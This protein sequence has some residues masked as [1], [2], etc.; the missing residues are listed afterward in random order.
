MIPF[1]FLIIGLT[2]LG[3]LLLADHVKNRFRHTPSSRR[4]LAIEAVIAL[5]LSEAGALLI[6]HGNTVTTR[7]TLGLATAVPVYIV[8]AFFTV[9]VWR[10]RKQEGFDREIARL[11]RENSRWQA[12]VERLN[13]ELKDL[14]RQ[15]H[16]REEEGMRLGARLRA[17][18]DQLQAWISND[19]GYMRSHQVD[20]WTAELSVLDAGELQAQKERMIAQAAEATDEERAESIA[21][22]HLVDLV[23]LR[24]AYGSPNGPI[25]ELEQRLLQVKEARAR[26]DRRLAQAKEELQRWQDR[27]MAFLREKIPLD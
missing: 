13:W 2:F 6:L 9:E 21:R 24:R 23:M 12:E 25:A 27:K 18:E 4:I 11:T 16:S 5:V 15:K 3:L 19:A 7:A 10:H 14:E 22:A 1:L 8:L 26:A 17:L 20:A